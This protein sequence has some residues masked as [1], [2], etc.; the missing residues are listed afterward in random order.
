MASKGTELEGLQR[1]QPGE[2]TGILRLLHEDI[3]MPWRTEYPSP[4]IHAGSSTSITLEEKRM[5]PSGIADDIG[6]LPVTLQVW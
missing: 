6:D 4:G 3:T 2:D 1:R 5:I